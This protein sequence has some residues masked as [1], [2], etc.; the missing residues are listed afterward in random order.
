[1][2]V[3]FVIIASFRDLKRGVFDEKNVVYLAKLNRYRS[4]SLEILCK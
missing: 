3:Y 4:L 2:G 1:M